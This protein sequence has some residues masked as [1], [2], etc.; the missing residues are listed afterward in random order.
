M[1]LKLLHWFREVI[2]GLPEPFRLMETIS[3]KSTPGTKKVRFE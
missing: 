1:I 2:L 3:P